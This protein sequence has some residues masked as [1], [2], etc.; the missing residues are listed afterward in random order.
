M[1][2]IRLLKDILLRGVQ[3]VMEREREV[4][5]WAPAA[6]CGSSL[7]ELEK[8][9][10]SEKKDEEDLM[11]CYTVEGPISGFCGCYMIVAFAALIIM[12]YI[13]KR[14][15]RYRGR[16]CFFLSLFYVWPMLSI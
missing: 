14:R 13:R 15:S 1:L 11:V 3:R 16:A 8:R 2:L 6:L 12:S 10:K 4:G 9:V 5:L 7:N